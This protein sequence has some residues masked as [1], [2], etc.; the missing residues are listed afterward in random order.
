[1]TFFLQDLQADLVMAV[2]LVDQVIYIHIKL[3]NKKNDFKKVIFVE[4]K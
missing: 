1:M 4:T 2:V 3:W